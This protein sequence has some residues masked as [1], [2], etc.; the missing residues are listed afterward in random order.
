[1]SQNQAQTNS[2]EE[3]NV[4]NDVILLTTNMLITTCKCHLYLKPRYLQASCI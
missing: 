1:L 4:K 2:D 3:N